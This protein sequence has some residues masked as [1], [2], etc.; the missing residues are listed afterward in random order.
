[1]IIIEC[2][3]RERPWSSP[4]RSPRSRT[5]RASAP[6]TPEVGEVVVSLL[7]PEIC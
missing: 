5:R 1:M 7:R 2:V 6:I 4:C 3:G